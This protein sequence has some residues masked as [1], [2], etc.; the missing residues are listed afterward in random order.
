E[1]TNVRAI[2][3]Q[4]FFYLAKGRQ[5]YAFLS[6]D[7]NY[8]LKFYK[9]QRFYIDP[10]FRTSWMPSWMERYRRERIK[11]KDE[12][13]QAL[14]YSAWIA[15]R[16]LQ[17]ETALCYIHCAPS[18][19]LEVQGTLFDKLGRSYTVDYDNTAFLLQRRVDG[20]FSVLA[21]LIASGDRDTARLRLDQ[22][23]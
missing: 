9:C 4:P 5:C 19:V 2:L 6:R 18:N 13:K 11:E 16:Y 23:V 10:L 14:F 12:R 1:L 21:P 20:L 3:K 17:R 22:I 15:Q 7:G 8:V